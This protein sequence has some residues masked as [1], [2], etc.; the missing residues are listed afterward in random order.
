MGMLAAGWPRGCCGV[1]TGVPIPDSG[2]QPGRGVGGRPG[3]EFKRRLQEDRPARPSGFMESRLPWA[4]WQNGAD[5]THVS[6]GRFWLQACDC[7][8]TEARKSQLPADEP[9]PSRS[10]WHQLLT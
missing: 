7:S 5:T 9:E 6:H 4:F 10:R 8:W 3:T 1:T 2:G